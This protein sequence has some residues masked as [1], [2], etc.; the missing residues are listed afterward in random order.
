MKLFFFFAR[1]GSSSNCFAICFT[2]ER[3]SIE[4]A[5][6]VRWT[7]VER[8]MGRWESLER[9]STAE[10]EMSGIAGTSVFM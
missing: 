4:T 6:G 7:G 2:R 9:E 5:E 1:P 8:E 3:E 10:E